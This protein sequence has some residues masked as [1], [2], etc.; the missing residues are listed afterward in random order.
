MK[1]KE[2]KTP[3][4]DIVL[5]LEKKM[6]FFQDVM[7]KT[8][9][10]VQNNKLLNILGIGE[11]NNCISILYE[12]ST[13][14]KEIHGIDA[15]S[16]E[17]TDNVINVLQHINNELSCLFKLFG[18]Q[19]FEDL[20]WVCFGNNSVNTYAISDMDKQKFELLKKHFH[21]IGY[22]VLSGTGT[23]KDNKDVETLNEKSKNL[24]M[25]DL[26]LKIKPFHMKV[27]GVQLVVHNMQHKK[28]LLISGYI[29]DVCV[30]LLNNSLIS[31]KIHA[32]NENVPSS[33]EFKDE[34]FQRFINSLT[35]KD[36]LLYDPHEIYSKYV[37]CLSALNTMHQK[38]T[39]QII[40]DFV[41][42]DLYVRRLMLIQLLIK[43]GRPDN[44]YL[45]YLLYDL[46]SNDAN[47]TVDSQEQNVLFD[48]L[49]WSIKESFREAMKTTNQY[50]HE[51]S[52]FDMQKIPLEQQ[53]CLLKAPD[54]VK[55]KAM[56][57]LKEIKAKSED[58]GSK[59]RQ[60]LDGLLKIP[61]SIYKKEPVL[62]LMN[63]IRLKYINGL[64]RLNKNVDDTANYTSVEILKGIKD[65][66]N[67]NHETHCLKKMEKW[68]KQQLTHCIG[69]INNYLGDKKIKISNKKK[70]DLVK[71]LE[72]FFETHKEDAK[73]KEIMDTHFCTEEEKNNKKEYESI[74][75]D[76]ESKYSEINK[77]MQNVKQ[78]LDKAVYG[79]EKAKKQV[80]RIIGQWINGDTNT[81]HILGFEGNPGIGKTSLAKGLASCLK[82]ENGVSRPFSVIMMGGD[83]NGS[84]L[85]GHS[86][87]YVG[88]TW[89]QIVQILIDNKC[90]NPI[91]LI[92]EVD[93]ISR[94]EHGKEIVGILTHL[95][96]STQNEH[97]QDKY[98][99]GIDLDLSKALFIL[100]YNDA[101]LIDRILLDRVHR[102]KFDSLSVDDKVVISKNYLLPELCKNLGLVD[103]V[104]FSDETLKCII[105]DYTMEPGVRKLKETL[106]NIVAELN[107]NILKNNLDI[108]NIPIEITINDIRNK[109]L[110]DKYRV[111][112]PKIH[113]KSVSHMINGMWAN[114]LSQGG[115]LQFQ[116]CFSPASSFLEIV[117]TGNQKEVMREGMIISR[118]IAWNLTSYE[119]QKELMQR[120]ND[121][122]NNCVCGINIHAGDLSVPK[123]GPSASSTMVV[124]FYALFN[125]IK[126]K[127]YFAMTG[128]I[129]LDGKIKEIGGLSSKI[130]GSIKNGVK[131]IIFPSEN[132]RDF[133]KFMEKYKDNKVI[134][135][136]KFHSAETI[137]DVFKLIF[138][139]D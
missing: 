88:S 53:I 134:E 118:N 39:S 103:M 7:Q 135:G 124:L 27:H 116:A 73:Y 24:D 64:K 35:L 91:I 93:K 37:G 4:S 112:V 43:S 108:H 62:N 10:H 3:P 77:C 46:L 130:L 131:E 32:I 41:T 94:T 22:K 89:G 72:T 51:L 86:Y 90:M 50:T 133:E 113:D 61:F 25:I 30:H 129:T 74:I 117:L 45:A 110:S 78:T 125:N 105:E 16:Q 9:I 114:Q 63:D 12:L 31:S 13:K 97:F 49:P 11:V 1:K 38:T 100:S 104:Y 8:A 79:H 80:E 76:I 82:D 21:P 81:G 60:Y 128:E 106:F 58:T 84:H 59:A 70:T 136:I 40:K 42:S 18:T 52:N 15:N 95:L 92:D 111:R 96:D 29:D 2:T 102:I 19:L 99:S 67:I 83:S 69:E 65:L 121:P 123:D 126:I 109:Y 28:S 68:D 23:K 137:E 20:L 101:D 75:C 127:N 115:I 122:K 98:F 14:L 56:Q 6:V 87:T 47:G 66:K 33:L 54:S 5:L 55:E 107:L 132:N 138:E 120:Y 48:S 36:Y 44:Q 119:K 57:K 17:K 85:V 139:H 34:T 71:E 26:S